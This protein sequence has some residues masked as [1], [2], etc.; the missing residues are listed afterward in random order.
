MSQKGG[1]LPSQ[2]RSERQESTSKRPLPI[3]KVD[4]AVGGRPPFAS[5]M[6]PGV[7]RRSLLLQPRFAEPF[8]QTIPIFD[9]ARIGVLI[10]NPSH[11]RLPPRHRPRGAA[12]GKVVPERFMG[13]Q[14]L[15]C[16]GK[17]GNEIE[18]RNRIVR[19]DL[20]RAA[21][22]IDRLIVLLQ[23]KMAARFVRIP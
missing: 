23:G 9:I 12:D 14:F 18:I 11:S 8:D 13:L 1:F 22:P 7:V 10:D 17:R 21:G 15:A 5:T 6:P 19:I 16:Q 4:G 20:D 2:G 3:A